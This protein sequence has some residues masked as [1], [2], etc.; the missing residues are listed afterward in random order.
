[1]RRTLLALF[2]THLLFACGGAP[3]A[4]PEAPTAPE[5]AAQ[6]A[7][8]AEAATGTAEIQRYDAQT[9]FETTSVFGAS[10]SADGS[11]VLMSS[12]QGGVFN[13]WSVAFETGEATQLTKS[14][15]D[16]H[17][18]VAYFP[19]DD[20]FLYTADQGGNEETHLYVQ[21]PDGT[22]KDLTPGEKLKASFGGFSR[23]GAHFYVWSNERDPKFFDVYRYASDG[24]A[25]EMVFE[26]TEGWSPGTVDRNG[27]YIAVGKV[28]NNADSD[29]YLID[30][31]GGSSAPELITKHEGNAT[32]DALQFT[33]DGKSL[34]YLT[35]AH[36][37]F[38]QAWR[39]DLESKTHTAFIQR[40]WDV[41]WAGYSETGKY[42]LVSTNEDATGKMELWDSAKGEPV[43][44]PKLPEGALQGITVA[45]SEDRLVLYVDRDQEP[46]NLYGL[47]IGGDTAKQLTDTLNP[48]IDPAHLV[49]S[50]VVR[51]P[52]FDDLEI[53]AILYR[54]HGASAANKVPAVVFVHGGP[55]GQSR[56]GYRAMFQHLVN[57]GYAVLAVNNRG[58]SGYGKTFFH[59]DDRKHG[60]V[61]LKDCIW[62]RRY[63]ESLDWVQ[64]DKVGIMGG[65][66]GGYMV[67]AALAFE[68]EAFELG[69]NIF[70]VTNWVR[71]LKSIPPWWASFREYLYAELGDPATDEARLKA[72]SPLFHA[73][74]IKRPLLVVQG[75]NDPRVLKVESDE[76]VE[77]V[78]ANG[79]PVEYLV[80]DDEGHG[81]RKKENRIAASEA[82][83]KFLDTHLRGAPAPDAQ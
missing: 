9:F 80:F 47:T 15:D 10:F 31:R 83:L 39:Y 71:T 44:L 63:L 64:G 18:A 46:R 68:P 22:V 50:T 55:G 79:V 35:N 4:V 32:H 76:I 77:A 56:R 1:M 57:H 26:N 49:E 23:D 37:E 8:V 33:P 21:H 30:L 48:A 19:K 16:A 7:K 36:G 3:P 62:G 61:D 13:V 38:E 28:K 41:T 11:R 2:A 70:G 24:Y 69:I 60:D 43:A 58:S 5:A 73:K 20:R 52:S 75:A 6:A 78:K 45:R 40:E 65:S 51:Y 25:R 81:F 82:Y 17:F 12:D 59:M 29:V 72:I 42:F 27:H 54:P 53:P 14:T 66:Y 67:A 74:N 34:L